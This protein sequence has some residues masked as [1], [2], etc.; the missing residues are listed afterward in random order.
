[1][2]YGT[3]RIINDGRTH[4]LMAAAGERAQVRFLEFFAASIRNAHTQR[5][6]SSAHRPKPSVTKSRL[7]LIGILH[8][9]R[10]RLVSTS[11]PE[12]A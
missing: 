2:T 12:K 3:F 1:M 10:T 7:R 4:A 8:G 6:C 11:A 5:A 9:R